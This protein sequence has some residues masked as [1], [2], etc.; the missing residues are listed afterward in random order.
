MVDVNPPAALL[1]TPLHPLHVELGAKMVPFAGYHM[2]SRTRLASWRAPAVPRLG[3]AVR[4]LAHGPA[5][6][7]RRRDAAA[8]LETLVPVD[9]V[10]LGAGRQR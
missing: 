1:K 10:D 2:P 7:G 4:R 9:V 3:G 6:P 8:A 5:A